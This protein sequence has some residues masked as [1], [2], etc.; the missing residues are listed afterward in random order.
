[1]EVNIIYPAELSKL[2]QSGEDIQI[3]DLR[4]DY[5]IENDGNSKSLH[6]PMGELVS[7]LEE[8][9]S[10]GKVVF[11]CSSGNRSMNILKFLIMNGLYQENYYHLEGGF[12]EW[13][14]YY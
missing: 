7:R 4:E 3:V 9:N 13:N 2:I 5:E 8:L 14:K 12:Q 6:I 10:S 1:M 11:H